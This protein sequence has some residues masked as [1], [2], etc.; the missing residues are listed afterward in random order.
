MQ[1]D[2]KTADIIVCGL[3]IFRNLL[4]SIIIRGSEKIQK[5]KFFDQKI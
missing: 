1:R 2:L 4:K 3:I 5:M